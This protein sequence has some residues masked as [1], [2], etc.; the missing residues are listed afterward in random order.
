MSFKSLNIIFK[1]QDV[2]M[3]EI[4]SALNGTKELSTKSDSLL[5]DSPRTFWK[6]FTS[7]K[8]EILI[9]ISKFDPESVYALAKLLKREPHHVLKD[10]NQLNFFGMINMIETEG[11]RKQIRPEL[12]FSYDIIKIESDLAE[13]LAISQRANNY[14]LEAV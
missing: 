12:K 9:A 4:D 6:F 5:F 2:F 14:L 7:N 13:V 10:C 11:S 3:G 8:M 1:E